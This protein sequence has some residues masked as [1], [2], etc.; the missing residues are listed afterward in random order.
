MTYLRDDKTAMGNMPGD[1]ALALAEAGAD[2]IGANCSGGPN[3]LQRILMKMRQSVDDATY[4]IM[5][6]AGWPERSG[7]RIFYPDATAYFAEQAVQFWMN[8]ADIIGGCCGT[9]AG[10]IFPPCKLL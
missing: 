3:Q 9:T 4:C 10:P 6:N 5:P 8:G 7:G 1:V 2:V